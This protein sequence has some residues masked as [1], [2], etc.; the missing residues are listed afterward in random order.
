[1]G[2]CPVVFVGAGKELPKSAANSEANTVRPPSAAASGPGLCGWPG[3]SLLSGSSDCRVEAPWPGP[4]GSAG[5]WTWCLAPPSVG[6]TWRPLGGAESRVLGSPI[7]CLGPWGKSGTQR[8][9]EK[10]V[11]GVCSE[12]VPPVQGTWGRRSLFR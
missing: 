7:A 9:L 1:M 11:G 3:S 5:A 10:K 2:P 8:R 6:S 4:G 12:H